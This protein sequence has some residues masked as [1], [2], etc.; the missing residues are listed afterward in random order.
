LR[1]RQDAKPRIGGAETCSRENFIAKWLHDAPISVFKAQ[2][3]RPLK[4]ALLICVPLALEK[5]VLL[6][7]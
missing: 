7:R 3:P 6:R 5:P 1:K 2:S 4:G